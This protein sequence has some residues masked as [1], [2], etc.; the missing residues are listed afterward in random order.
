[1]H[2]REASVQLEQ[3]EVAQRRGVWRAVLPQAI[4][5][6]LAESAIERLS[7]ARLDQF[8]ANLTPR[9]AT[10]FTRRIGYLHDNDRARELTA[11]LLQ[12]DGP[13]GDLL[14]FSDHSLQMLHNLAPVAPDLVLTRI[15][16]AVD[17][18]GG[19]AILNPA[20]GERWQLTNLLRSIRDEI[21]PEVANAAGHLLT[22]EP[23]QEQF[24]AFTSMILEDG[25]WID[26]WRNIRQVQ[27]YRIEGWPPDLQE[28]VS[29]LE[30]R[31]RPTDR[32]SEIQAWVLSGHS[33]VDLVEP[34]SDSDDDSPSDR[35]HRAQNKA[36]ELGV[37]SADDGEALYALFP[38]LMSIE[39]GYEVS[40]FGRGLAEA[41]SN[42]EQLWRAM[43]SEFERLDG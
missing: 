27:R 2:N 37:A 4:A 38:D 16:E 33:A 35:Y 15:A 18:P 43:V 39:H 41:S 6:R 23:S 8:I 36:R 26:G 20:F 21:A 13:F 1:M 14:S 11:R 7:N 10:S 40:L 12:S 31:L 42:R 25:P 19:D 34:A 22:N 24:D 9:M 29:E 3:R 32:A 5:N 30:L 28:Y 17:G